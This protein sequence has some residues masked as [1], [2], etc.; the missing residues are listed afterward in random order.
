VHGV[1]APWRS[2]EGLV[3]GYIGTNVDITERRQAEENRAKLEA[4]LQEAQ[5]MESVG[6]LAGGV[7]HDFYNMLGVILGFTEMALL[8]VDPA[9]QLHEDLEEIRKA[10]TRSADLTRQLLAFARRQTVMP[11]VLDLNDAVTGLFKMVQRLIGENIELNWY[12]GAEL[13]PVRL[14]PS[15]VDQILANLCVNARDAMA[16]FGK[17]TVRTENRRADR[18]YCAGRPDFAPGEYVALSVSDDGCGMD[19]AAMSHIFEPFFTTKEVGKGTGLGLATVYGIVK[20][21]EGYVEVRSAPGQGTTF[22]VYLPRHAGKAGEARTGA[23]A[24]PAVRGHETILLVEDEPSFLKLAA[25]MLERLGYT[26]LA[27]GTPGA[28][29]RIARAHAGDISMLITDVI[30][31][32]MNGRDLARNL[33]SLYPRLKRIFMSGYTADVIAHQGVL[34]EGTHFIQKPFTTKELADSVRGVLDSE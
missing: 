25:S 23:A 16:E 24:G 12:P 3:L 5:K 10:A 1:A 13:W 28:A 8:Q 26:V 4:Q 30:M 32:E 2:S 9:L 11:R 27:A 14:D 7:A 15:Q 19:A 22:T 29:L 6:R 31:P 33:L 18:D 20:Q 21:N 34:D 17:L